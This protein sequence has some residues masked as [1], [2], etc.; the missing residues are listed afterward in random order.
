MVGL[1]SLGVLSSWVLLAPM[2]FG[3]YAL[4]KCGVPANNDIFNYPT[5]LTLSWLV[6]YLLHCVA[7]DV[8]RRCSD[9]ASV[10]RSILKWAMMSI[11][12]L[13]LGAVW[14]SIPPVLLGFLVE[15]L[16][17]IPVRTP[18]QETPQYPFLQ[19]WA[20]GLIILKVWLRCVLSGVFG[21]IELRTQLELIIIRG[22]AQ[23]DAKHCWD[24]LVLPTCLVLMDLALVPYFCA[25]FLS[26]GVQSYTLRTLL[27]RFS[28]HS[29]IILRVSLYVAYHSV[30]YLVKLHNEVRDSKYLIGTQLTNRAT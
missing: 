19:C 20:I 29:Y 28:F 2:A 1:I 10:V 18:I 6:L 3:R 23:F 7:K 14:L 13:L 16:F 17:L 11:K 4:A 21:D 15:A 27:V 25:R 22:F 8:Q 26:M 12:A 30:R 9:A 5:G 24:V